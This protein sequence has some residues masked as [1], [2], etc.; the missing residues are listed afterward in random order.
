MLMMI[1]KVKRTFCAEC[2]RKMGWEKLTPTPAVGTGQVTQNLQAELF[3]VSNKICNEATSVASGPS[4]EVGSSGP[5]LTC[6]V[7]MLP[8]ITNMKGAKARTAVSVRPSVL[9]LVIAPY[10][11]RLCWGRNL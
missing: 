6:N 3:E 7:L 11:C 4:Q 1:V 5:A 8:M 9:A 2:T 10:A